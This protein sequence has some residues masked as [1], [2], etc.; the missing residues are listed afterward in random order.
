M[1]TLFQ[2]L[3]LALGALALAGTA[4]A[5]VPAGTWAGN[6]ISDST[7]AN[8]G[9]GTGALGGPS[10]PNLTGDFNTASGY[11]ALF[12]NTTGKLNTAAGA[13][14]LH[15]NTSGSYNAACGNEALGSNQTGSQNTASGAFALESNTTGS[16]NTAS[17]YIALDSNTTGSDNT[18]SGYYA[19]L[20]NKN[21]S[22]NSAYGENALYTATASF[23]TAVGYDSLY[24]NKTGRYNVAL[25]WKAGFALTTGD[26]NIDIDNQGEASESDTIR[27]GTEGIQTAT[28]IAGIV[29]GTSVTGPYVVINSTTGQ[30][31]V[32][33]TPPPAGVKTASYVPKLLREM[34]QQAA[35][36]RDLKQ[37]Q[38][39]T[40]EQ[41]AELKALNQA[42]MTA[43]QKLQAKDQLVAQR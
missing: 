18:A 5:Q 29:N 34:R 23:N 17:G 31:G 1:K 20:S 36:I 16:N 25:G 3:L 37:Q 35:E 22:Q 24:K 9:M 7:T 38:L 14:A 6:D 21:G 13:T 30:L 12:S 26:N 19:L 2:S 42:T 39:Q 41:V 4:Y 10:P 33:T 15:S 40:L 43:L 32:S 27:I 8:T 11:N 28:Y